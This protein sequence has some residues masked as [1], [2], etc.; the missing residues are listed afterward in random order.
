MQEGVGQ[1]RGSV[2]FQGNPGDK[3]CLHIPNEINT[4]PRVV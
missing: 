4:F 2:T 1:E 3:L